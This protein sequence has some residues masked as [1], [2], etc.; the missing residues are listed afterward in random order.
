MILACGGFLLLSWPQ[1]VALIVLDQIVLGAG[2]GLLSTP[3]LVG[4]QSVVGWEK[5]GVVTGANMFG[6]YLGQCLG[7]AVFGAIFNTYFLSQ[8]TKAPS[9][10]SDKGT[11]VLQILRSSHLS[12]SAKH[13]LEI[14]I[15]QSTR[16]IYIGLLIFAV[17]T[18]LAVCMTPRH[19]KKID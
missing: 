5:R 18:F 3:M 7:S 12:E 1:S 13:F 16:H 14:T 15:N 9:E 8:M 2:F 17:L 4:V 10:L 11:N 6:R 19:F